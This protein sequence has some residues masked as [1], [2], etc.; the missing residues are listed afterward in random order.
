MTPEKQLLYNLMAETALAYWE[1]TPEAKDITSTPWGEGFGEIGWIKPPHWAIKRWNAQK[2]QQKARAKQNEELAEK[3]KL[4]KRNLMAEM[5]AYNHGADFR[6]LYSDPARAA[7]MI[8]M[9]WLKPKSHA[10]LP[11]PMNTQYELPAK[12][13]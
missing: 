5:Y 6:L 2:K 11:D 12:S 8:L 7:E 3:A 13:V 1:K 9:D 4:P 10:L